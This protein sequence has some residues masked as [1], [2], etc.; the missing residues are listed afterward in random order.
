MAQLTAL[1]LTLIIEGPLVYLGLFR[2][3]KCLA[4][5]LALSVIPTLITHPFLW[6]ASRNVPPFIPHYWGILGLELAVVVAEGFLLATLGQ[7]RFFYCMV[8]SLVAN[9]A[10]MLIGIWLWQYFW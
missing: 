4:R 7:Q 3:E 8:V 5:L 9:A 1:I 6:I 2:R 10:S